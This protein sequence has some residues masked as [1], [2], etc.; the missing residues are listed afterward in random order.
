MASCSSFTTICS[1]NSPDKPGL[2]LWLWMYTYAGI[3]GISVPGR[4]IQVNKVFQ[5]SKGSKSR[6]LEVKATDGNKT[7]KP[8]SIVCTGCEGNGAVACSQCKGSGVNSEDHF[9]GRFKVGGMCWL[10]RGKREMLC[11]SCN[12]AGFLGGLMSTIDD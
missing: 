4:V 8:R 12:G 3:I 10:C 6:S 1:L 5:T 2:N 7:V 11:G 9:N